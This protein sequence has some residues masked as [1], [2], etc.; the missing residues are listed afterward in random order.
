MISITV[1]TN[2]KRKQV[3]VDPN[4]TVRQV[5]E[6]NGVNYSVGNINLDAKILNQSDLD[7]TLTELGVTSGAYIINVA[8]ADN[9]Q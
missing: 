4:L 2:T 8:K 6:Q 1:G 3:V 5:L 7:K 9:A